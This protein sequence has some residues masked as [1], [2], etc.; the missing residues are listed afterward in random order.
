MLVILLVLPLGLMTPIRPVNAQDAYV[1]FYVDQPLGYIPFVTP[2]DKVTVNIMINTSNIT[3]GTGDGIVG[4]GVNVQFDPDVLDINLTA[5]PPPPFPPPPPPAKVIG[6]EAGY[7]LFEYGQYYGITPTLMTG[8]SD[9]ATGCWEDIAETFMPTP[10]HGAG[11]LM[12]SSYP[13]LVTLEVT[14]KSDTQPCVIELVSAYYKTPVDVFPVDTLRDGY[15][16]QAPPPYAEFAYTPSKPLVDQ[17]VTFNASGSYDPDGGNETYPSGIVSYAWDFGDETP[18]TGNVTTHAYAGIGTYTVIL[19]VTDDEGLWDTESKNITIYGPPV[20]AFTYS[21]SAPSVG[22]MVTF[23]ASESYDPDGG[24]IVSFDWDFGDETT[25]TEADPVTTYRYFEAATYTVTLNVTDDEGSTNSTTATVTVSGAAAAAEFSVEV[26]VGSIYF[27][28]ETTE[29]YILTSFMGEPVN[30]TQ[31]D[32]RLYYGGALHADLSSSVENVTTGLYRVPYEVPG[33]APSGTYALVVNATFITQKGISLKTFLISP[34]LTGWNALLISIEGTVGTIETRVGLIAVQLDSINATLVDV[35]GTVAIINSTLGSIVA[36]VG[37]IDAKLTDIEGDIA[38]IESDLG[39]IEADINDINAEISDIDGTLVTIQTDIGLIRTNVTAINTTLVDIQGGVV[40]MGSTL[41]EVQLDL[42]DVKNAISF[43][44]DSIL[45]DIEEGLA[46]VTA[47]ITDAEG[48]ILLE[49]GEV[50][51]ELADISATLTIVEGD[52]VT[53]ETDIGTIKGKITSI[54]GDIATIETDIGAIRAIL[55]DWT[56]VATSLIT[57][58]AG[59]FKVMLV[60]NS[61]LEGPATFS[62]NTLTLVVSGQ[63]GTTGILNVKIP[64]QLLVGLGSNIDEFAVTINGTPVSFTYTEEGELYTVRIL[65]A[66]STH[67]IKVHLSRPEAPL[68]LSW[69]LL[70][71]VLTAVIPAVVMTRYALKTRKKSAKS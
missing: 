36:D 30:A 43:E 29:F 71:A 53:I 35:N 52:I 17:T 18:G 21:P 47:A 27:R 58:P 28:G 14:S 13:K 57:T 11:D 32:A 41:G 54:Q 63:T 10:T 50:E 34:T 16:G 67:T 68:Q 8:S 23:N 64:R 6:A 45:G 48:N 4:W 42:E 59:A 7:F 46:N 22:E 9:P 3:D 37:T 51:V 12:S 49:L 5:P 44:L 39:S 60:T 56:G 55:E 70:V 66:H 20:A 33:D 69:I 19:N 25:V 2:G 24:D 62:D 26:D 1:E 40:T 65:Y 31:I 38:T 15:Y 61:T